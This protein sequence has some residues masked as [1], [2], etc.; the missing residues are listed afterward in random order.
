MV[1]ASV[2]LIY[3][4][5]R[6]RPSSNARATVTRGISLCTQLWRSCFSFGKCSPLGGRRR[7]GGQWTRAFFLGRLL[8]YLISFH[9]TPSTYLEARARL[10]SWGGHSE[11]PLF[12][13]IALRMSN[14]PA[15]AEERHPTR[16]PG[17]F[18][19]LG[20]S[21]LLSAVHHLLRNQLRTGVCWISSSSARHPR[22]DSQS[23]TGLTQNAPATVAHLW[24]HA[25]FPLHA[26]ICR[27]NW[28]GQAVRI[29]AEDMDFFDPLIP[30]L[31]HACIGLPR[32]DGDHDNPR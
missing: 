30:E 2:P 25:H 1:A 26:H 10:D 13:N 4:R 31:F 24:R 21:T 12:S 7:R 28:S 15:S 3:L 8:G 18:A 27:P 32:I 20:A 16:S 11:S 17:T 6:S 9:L 23:C 5:N 19:C 29:G 14:A 22:R